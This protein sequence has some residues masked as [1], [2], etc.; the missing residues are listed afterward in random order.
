MKVFIFLST[1]YSFPELDELYQQRTKKLHDRI[2]QVREG[3]ENEA[4]K[5]TAAMAERRKQEAEAQVQLEAQQARV[6]F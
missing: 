2:K 3:Y 5:R 4:K 6:Q 1:C